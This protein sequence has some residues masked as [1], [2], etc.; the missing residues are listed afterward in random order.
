MAERDYV[1]G[2]HDDEIYRLGLQ[3][4]VWRARVLDAWTRAGIREGQRVIDCGAGPGFATMDLAE[5]VGPKGK[6]LAFERSRRFLDVLEAQARARALSNIEPFEVD[7]ITDALPAKDADAAWVRWVLAFL[8][9]P[10]A[11]LRKL[12]DALRPGGVLVIYE[13]LH[14]RTLALKPASA[15]F[16]RFVDEVV[17]NWKAAGGDPDAGHMTPH[18]LSEM[19]MTLEA[20]RPHIDIISPTDAMWAWPESFFHLHIERL[21]ELRRITAQDAAEMRAEF[22]RD[23]A[24][25][26]ARMVTPLVVEIIARK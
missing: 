6:V 3:H 25:P 13:Y 24:K 8:P 22:A 2:T 1:L 19:G 14:Y 20:V 17:A 12:V 23:A 21:L 7:L 9:D 15:S 11:A 18:W 16:E 26:G 4:R 5:I 10:K